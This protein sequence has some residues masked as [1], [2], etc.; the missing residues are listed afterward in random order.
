MKKKDGRRSGYHL[1]YGD[2]LNESPWMCFFFLNKV[3]CVNLEGP[4]GLL[5]M[6]QAISCCF[7][8][9]MEQHYLFQSIS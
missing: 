7:G 8:R 6:D 3:G 2:R 9:E 1:G 5:Q 4:A